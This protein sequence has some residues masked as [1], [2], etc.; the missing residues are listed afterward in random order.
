MTFLKGPDKQ[1]T[2][3]LSGVLRTLTVMSGPLTNAL[4]C[5][6]ISDGTAERMLTAIRLEAKVRQKMVSFYLAGLNFRADS[7]G[8]HLWFPLPLPLPLPERIKF[9][10]SYAVDKLREQ[11]SV[12]FLALFFARI[13]TPMKRF[14]YALV[15]LNHA[16]NVKKTLKHWPKCFRIHSIFP[17]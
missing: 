11:G 4:A 6:W 9:N 16:S 14:V 17:A 10:S 7:N 2:Q 5:Q 8:Y 15:V 13:I 1:S 12:L 3:L